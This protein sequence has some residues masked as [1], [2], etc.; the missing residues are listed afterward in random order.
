MKIRWDF[1]TNSSSTSFVIICQGQPSKDVFLDA[2]GARKGSPL[3]PLFERLYEVLCRK[4]SNAV[5]ALHSQYWRGADSVEELVTREI[6]EQVGKEAAAAREKGLD[7]FIGKLDSDE[8]D[9][10]AF[11]CCESFE[12]NHPRLRVNALRCAW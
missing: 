12:V 9:V 2:M 8:G 3:W 11:F 5:D 10:E 6:S 1:V 7:V 4:M